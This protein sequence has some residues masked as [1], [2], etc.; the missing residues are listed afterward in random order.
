[1]LVSA[2]GLSLTTISTPSSLGWVGANQLCT[3]LAKP[4]AP[5]MAPVVA[6]AVV[7]TAVDFRGMLPIAAGCSGSGKEGGEAD[8]ANGLMN[9][10]GRISAL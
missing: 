2:V 4:E 8:S 6:P 3:F 9:N 7:S 10:M 1:M 5:E